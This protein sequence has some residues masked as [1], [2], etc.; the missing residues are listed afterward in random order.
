M[1]STRCHPNTTKL[2]H[3]EDAAIKFGWYKLHP[4]ACF[5]EEVA[6]RVGEMDDDYPS[7]KAIVVA[8]IMLAETKEAAAELEAG[9][10][11]ILILAGSGGHTGYAYALAQALLRFNTELTFLTPVDE[12]H[13]MAKLRSLG[14]VYPLVKPRGPRT[15]WPSF[16]KNLVKSFLSSSRQVNQKFD[17]VVSTGSNFCLAPSIIAWLKGIPLVN[18]ESSERFVT[19]SKTARVLRPIAKITALAWPEQK[20]RIEGTVV[21]PLMPKPKYH[22]KGVGYTLVTGGTYGHKALFDALNKTTLEN[23]VLQTNGE[24]PGQYRKDHPLWEVFSFTKNFEWLL[25]GADVVVTHYGYTVLEATAHG[26][27]VVIVPNPEWTLAPSLRDA[28]YMVQK[29]NGVLLRTLTPDGLERAVDEARGRSVP[30]M[31]DGAN[32]LACLVMGL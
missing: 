9:Q 19:V 25:A 20:T 24:D 27:P 15:S 1:A 10:K 13:S 31:L 18:I 16:L 23:I 2:I 30:K 21:G 12:P 14:K 32:N 4:K 29:I 6:R 3:I 28:A 5:S 26:K 22:R 11:R 17:L 7:D 8:L